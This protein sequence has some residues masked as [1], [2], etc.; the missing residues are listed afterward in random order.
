MIT[1][2]HIDLNDFPFQDR[3][4]K[5]LHFSQEETAAT[6]VLIRE[7]LKKNAIKR[8]RHEAGDFISTIFLRR[9]ANGSWRLIL[10]LKN[11]NFYVQYC[12]FKMETLA[13]ILTLVTRGCWLM[14]IDF[15]DAYL[16][17]GICLAHQKLLKFVW[18]GEVFQFCSMPFGLGEAPRKWT[19]LMKAPLALIRQNGYTIAAYLDD[20]LQA[21]QTFSLCEQA[22]KMAYEFLISLGFIPNYKK[23]VLIPTQR[24]ESL[25]HIIDSQLMQITLPPS[26]AEAIVAICVAA[27]RDR[28]MSIRWMCTIIGKLISCFMVA[29]LGR[30]HYRNLERQKVTALHT[31][32]GNFEA[33][34][35]LNDKSVEDLVWWCQNL[36]TT[37][38][39]IDR[40]CATSV[41]TCDASGGSKTAVG[42]WGA[43][44]NA[45]KAH[46]QFSVSE[47]PLSINT[48]ELLAV[49]YGLRSFVTYF[50]GQHVLCMSDSVTAVSVV[51]AMGSMDSLLHDT[52]A[53]EIWDFAHKHGIWLS[54]TYLPG[55]LNFESDLYSRCFNVN[56]EWCLPQVIFDAL[57]ELYRPLGPIIM[58]LFASRLNYRLKPYIAWIPDPHCC[59][60]DAFSIPWDSPYIYYAY[61][62]FSVLYRLVQK[63][64][65]E[66]ATVLT[67]FPLWPTQFWFN[68]LLDL[69]ITDITLLPANPPVFLPWAPQDQH[70]IHKSLK[71]CAA[72]LSGKYSS[73]M[74]YQARL[75]S[76]SAKTDL[77]TIYQAMRQGSTN[78]FSFVWRG[79]FIP[80]RPLWTN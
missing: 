31:N 37:A 68:R 69:L 79:K 3:P 46:G 56:T 19:K 5:P 24:I 75:Q 43:A 36:P 80:V 58:D 35:V 1:G 14:S 76:S 26:K 54:T 6:D 67:I 4:P 51:K 40:G 64:T 62:P 8:S 77:T 70:P 72:V 48:K 32:S 28:L 30:L 33:L 57:V 17:V 39:P 45:L 12:K 16:L 25:S 23:S 9:K 59:H 21:E 61:C 15:S 55:K 11:F 20:L 65:T 71:L 66:G 10:N 60:V 63:I 50:E 49:L 47:Q 44:Y 74:N 13:R 52:I 78:G 34:I 2:M 27:I 29:P 7:L 53:H 38:A 18:N 73:R 41:F 42:G 22:L